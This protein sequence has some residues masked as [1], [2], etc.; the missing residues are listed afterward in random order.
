MAINYKFRKRATV[1]TQLYLPSGTPTR[2]TFAGKDLALDGKE[3]DVSWHL[4]TASRGQ[5]NTKSFQTLLTKASTDRTLETLNHRMVDE[6][7][8]FSSETCFVRGQV[9]HNFLQ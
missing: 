3:W 7:E 2:A 6:S 4:I 8:W 1:F 5:P 9:T